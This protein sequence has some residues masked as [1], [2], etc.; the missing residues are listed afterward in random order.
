MRRIQALACALVLTACGPKARP[1]A[2]SDC[3]LAGSTGED[4]PRDNALVL[5]L[6]A[7]DTAFIGNGE[8]IQPAALDTVIAS[9]F[10]HLPPGRR[11]FFVR[12]VPPTRCAD[13][14]RVAAVAERHGGQAFDATA[15]GWPDSEPAMPQGWSVDTVRPH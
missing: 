11:A 10:T 6:P 4:A 8:R 15:S 3:T 2:A 5:E 1:Q 7:Y 9:V 12:Q 14:R 13:V